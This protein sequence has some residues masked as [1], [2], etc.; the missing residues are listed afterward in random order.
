MRQSRHI[1]EILVLMSL[2]HGA[3]FSPVGGNVPMLV[4]CQHY[5]VITKGTNAR[6]LRL[7]VRRVNL[8]ELLID[9]CDHRKA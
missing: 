3:L 8:L 7:T 4:N 2:Q 1:S 9:S 6:R 5:S